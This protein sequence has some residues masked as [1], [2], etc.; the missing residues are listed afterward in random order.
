MLGA[1]ADLGLTLLRRS[2]RA[3]DAAAILAALQPSADADANH[4]IARDVVELLERNLFVREPRL[5]LFVYAH[6]PCKVCRG[7]AVMWLLQRNAC[8]DWLRDEARH[9]ALQ[10]TREACSGRL[11]SAP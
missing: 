11:P 4:A 7:E 2:A 1:D 5:A 3:E 8:P 9:D 10:Q 6:S